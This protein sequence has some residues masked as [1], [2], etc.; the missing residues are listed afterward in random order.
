MTPLSILLR[1]EKQQRVAF[2][3]TLSAKRCR[4]EACINWAAGDR[5]AGVG[6]TSEHHIDLTVDEIGLCWKHV[7]AQRMRRS[8]VRRAP[9]PTSP[10]LPAAA[11]RR[12]S[13]TVRHRSQSELREHFLQAYDCP[14]DTRSASGL[15]AMLHRAIACR[16]PADVFSHL[17][18]PRTTSSMDRSPIILQALLNFRD[19]KGFLPLQA[20]VAIRLDESIVTEIF[21][22]APG[23]AQDTSMEGLTAGLWAVERM[24]YSTQLIRSLLADVPRPW[25]HRLLRARRRGNGSFIHHYSGLRSAT[26]SMLNLLLALAAPGGEVSRTKLKATRWRDSNGRT[27]LHISCMQ[28]APTVTDGLATYDK[29][30]ASMV[31]NEGYSPIFTLLAHISEQSIPYS[32]AEI[33]MCIAA[34]LSASPQSLLMR[35]NTGQTLLHVMVQAKTPVWL[36]MRIMDACPG[37]VGARDRDGRNVLHCI[38]ASLIPW[39]GMVRH[40]LRAHKSAPLEVDCDSKTPLWELLMNEH[41]SPHKPSGGGAGGATGWKY[42]TCNIILRFCPEAAQSE[43]IFREN[44]I[45]LHFVLSKGWYDLARLLDRYNPSE[46]GGMECEDKNGELPLHAALEKKLNPRMNEDT[47]RW[48]VQTY[49][50]GPAHFSSPS[51]GAKTKAAAGAVLP[52]HLAQ[53]FRHPEYLKKWLIACHVGDALAI[54]QT[55]STTLKA[56]IALLLDHFPERALMR[57]GLGNLPLHYAI[58]ADADAS[59]IEALLMLNPSTARIPDAEGLAPLLLACSCRGNMHTLSHLKTIHASAPDAVTAHAHDKTAM[60]YAVIGHQPMPVVLWL[61]EIDQWQTKHR[62]ARGKAP[63]HYAVENNMRDCAQILLSVYADLDDLLCR[64]DMELLRRALNE[65]GC[66]F[67]VDAV[68]GNILHRLATNQHATHVLRAIAW[69]QPWLVRHKNGRGQTPMDVAREVRED[70]ISGSPA[71]LLPLVQADQL[72]LPQTRAGVSA[73]AFS[74]KKKRRA[75]MPV[76]GKSRGYAQ[77]EIRKSALSTS[78]FSSEMRGEFSDDSSEEE[79]GDHPRFVN[80]ADDPAEEALRAVLDPM[81]TAIGKQVG[82][83][84]DNLRSLQCHRRDTIFNL[85]ATTLQ[86]LR[87]AL[88]DFRDVPLLPILI[89]VRWMGEGFGSGHADSEIQLSTLA[90]LRKAVGYRKR[91]LENIC[92]FSHFKLYFLCEAPFVAPLKKKR[93]KADTCLERLRDSQLHE[94]FVPD[95][96]YS[97]DFAPWPHG[98]F[99]VVRPRREVVMALRPL[100]VLSLCVLRAGLVAK[101]MELPADV[102]SLATHIDQPIDPEEDQRHFLLS[103]VHAWGASVPTLFREFP[104]PLQSD[105]LAFS[106]LI[107]VFGSTIRSETERLDAFGSASLEMALLELRGVLERV[108]QDMKSSP[109]Y[110]LKKKTMRAERARTRKKNE[111]FD[112]EPFDVAVHSESGRFVHVCPKHAAAPRSAR[113]QVT[114]RPQRKL[115]QMAED[116]TE[117]LKKKKRKTTGRGEKTVASRYVHR[118]RRSNDGYAETEIT[119]FDEEGEAA[120]SSSEKSMSLLDSIQNRQPVRSKRCT[121][122]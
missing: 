95:G 48:L 4:H 6:A 67:M 57:D 44:R 97:R 27:P 49:P 47:I 50:D 118:K 43:N 21:R 15:A 30:A 31:D 85:V 17:L 91:A 25:L 75:R 102:A 71:T 39:V 83:I 112:R 41:F 94:H 121:V 100:V 10:L 13:A 5:F 61:I 81:W 26:I 51:K 36:C 65:R 62:D 1:D 87:D 103:A 120:S 45:P 88:P 9:L 46:T 98:G 89:P 111:T 59:I 3:A 74:Q 29:E 58:R 52:L 33:E 122:Q 114:R 70:G 72:R 86:H 99:N 40:I 23:A 80:L 42:E 110:Q 101:E 105:D 7:K 18:K 84:E 28:G 115:F 90:V 8:C 119:F 11:V 22:L 38:C 24:T 108:Q 93:P 63:A 106:Y 12:A 109:S 78:E 55:Q 20:A 79:D 113:F 2:S 14:I 82:T 117:K 92:D 60:H 69:Y 68:G 107:D 104:Q 53:K 96:C 116:S 54:R 73:G 34:L 64:M 76:G 32:Q 35:S 56:A 37:L 19:T 77:D 16:D 66:V